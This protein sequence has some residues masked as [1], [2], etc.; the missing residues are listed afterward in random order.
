MGSFIFSTAAAFVV[1][2][3]LAFMRPPAKDAYTF[4]IGEVA[5]AFGPTAT[6]LARYI[7]L[8]ALA[9]AFLFFV[10]GLH[11]F[12]PFQNVNVALGFLCGPALGIWLNSII[13][14][15]PNEGLH[16][17]QIIGGIG[18]VILFI[19]GSIGNEGVEVIKRYSSHISSLKFGIA[20]FSFAGKGRS[21]G[22]PGAPSTAPAGTGGKTFSS[23]QGLQY[24][25]NLGP[26]FVDRDKQYLKLF[27]ASD[28]ALEGKLEAI[29]K[30]AEEV[31]DPPLSCLSNWSQTAIDA[32]SIERHLRSYAEIFRYLPYLKNDA[33]RKKFVDLFLSQSQF[34]ASDAEMF[35][36]S[37]KDDTCKQLPKASE[38]IEKDI[39]ALDD[40]EFEE[41]PYLAIAQA[42]VMAQLAQYPAAGAILDNWLTDKNA[43]R[44]AGN[45]PTS[46]DWLE[47]RARSVLAA[48]SEEWVESDEA[49]VTTT[50]R[51]E[52]LS[53]L[54]LLRRGLRRL[55]TTPGFFSTLL[56]GAMREGSLEFKIPSTCLFHDEGGRP[57][58][59]RKLFT[60]YISI[61]LT[62]DQNTLLYPVDIYDERF[63][64]QTTKNLRALVQSDLSCVTDDV[65]SKVLYA[66]ILEAFARNAILYAEA[67]QE[68]ESGSIRESRLNDATRATL[69]GLEIV[70]KSAE[71]DQVR[72]GKS[73][74]SRI[75]A[76]DAL[77]TKEAL[78]INLRRLKA[79]TEE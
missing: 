9:S 68:A 61:E 49:N 14:L 38:V 55:V 71:V 30:F 60:S 27:K 39:D 20:E 11:R 31:I 21:D 64:E 42:S 6:I 78:T 58:L 72:Q 37:S 23:S 12:S 43:H 32:V 47:L 67:R 74:T 2:E 45:W 28:S 25:S 35:I 73:Y 22:T 66:E 3:F 34:L 56:D 79:L 75:A 29:N 59:W 4:S 50:I 5:V 62:Y 46:D 19:L 36:A 48:Y 57:D 53:N 54:D 24:V 44:A 65:D 70:M 63:A 76:S 51:D 1:Y 77:A 13:R 16:K 40:H 7:F 33:H 8:A 18:L 17:G 10:L 41:R 26:W 52:H 69:T 15:P